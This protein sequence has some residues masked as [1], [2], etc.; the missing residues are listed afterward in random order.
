MARRACGYPLEQ[1][2]WTTHLHTIRSD[3][4]LTAGGMT[5]LDTAV[6]QVLEEKLPAQFGGAPTDYQLVE[7]EA[8]DGQSRLRLIVHPALGTLAPERVAEAFLQGISR[9]DGAE[10]LMGLVWRDAKLLRV[11]RR[12]PYATAS[13]KILHLHTMPSSS[14][15]GAG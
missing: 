11:E 13:G 4:K 6:M 7:D 12:V 1:L 14:G 10:R 15:G 9:G 2:G 3:E 8:D 5:F